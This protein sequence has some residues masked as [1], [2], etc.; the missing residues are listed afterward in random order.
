[1][2]DNASSAW[3]DCYWTSRDGLRLHYRDY[4]ADDRPGSRDRPALLCLPGL[5]RNAR[6]FAALAERFAGAWR[7]IAPDMRGRGDSAYARDSSTYNPGQYVEDIGLLLAEAGIARYIAIGTSLGGLMTMLLA[8]TA[9]ERIAGAVLNDVGPVIEAAGLARIGSYVGQGRS[10]PTWMHAA[11]AIEETQAA[12]YPGFGIDDW[13]ALAKRLMVLSSNGRIV[14]D[15]DM[16]IAEP[17]ARIEPGTQ[18]DLW[19]GIANLAGKPVLLLRGGLSDLLSP[20]T[21]EQMRAALPGAEA[22]TLPDVGHAPTLDEPA[23]V[24]AIERLLARCL[25]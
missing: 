11:R 13:L 9:P 21:L 10:F 23:A 12:A 8:M 3:A 14:F 6:D 24:A 4:P 18:P 17:L 20:A 1:M 5:T 7:V 16:R 25:D 15:Y 22:V 19:P 2:A